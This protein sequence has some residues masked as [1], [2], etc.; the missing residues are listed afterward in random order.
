M[1]GHLETLAGLEGGTVG[2]P[3]RGVQPGGLICLAQFRK[4]SVPGSNLG[5]QSMCPLP[6]TPGHHG[7]ERG[8]GM[9]LS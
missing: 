7:S 5:G 1:W 3:V 8:Q 6:Y 9:V 4:D 2:D